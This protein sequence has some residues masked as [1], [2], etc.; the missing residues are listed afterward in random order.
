MRVLAAPSFVLLLFAFDGATGMAQEPTVSVQFAPDARIDLDG[1]LT[2]RAWQ[3]AGRIPELFQQ[4]PN[5][6]QPTAFKTQVRILTDGESLYI[7]VLA[8]DPRPERIAVHSMRRDSEMEGDDTFSVVLDTF[9]DRRSAFLFRINPAGARQDG[10]IDSSGELSLDW[11]GIWDAAVHRTA[12]G[13]TAEIEIPSKTLRFSRD[14]E[15]W[16]FNAERFV[17]RD[18]LTLRWA[19]TTLDARLT[20]LRRAG[21]LTGAQVMKQGL[22]LSITPF[23]LADGDTGVGEAAAELEG[24][25]GLDVTYSFT[26]QLS[27]VGTINTDFAETEVDARQVN[28]TRFPLFFPEKRTFFLE[29]SNQF[30]FAAGLEENFIPFFSRR[31]GLVAGREVP[32]IGGLKLVGRQGNLGIGLL[33]VQTQDLEDVGGMELAPGSNL[34]AG[35]FTYDANDELRLGAILTNGN[36]GSAE[37]N[38][39]V[40]A[41]LNWATS[42]FL[43]DRNLRLSGWTTRSYGDLREGQRSGWGIAAFYPNDLWDLQAHVFQFGA[44][45][46]P[47]LG[48]LPRPGT[49]RYRVEANWQP[50]PTAAWLEWMRQYFVEF[51]Y[52]RVDDLEGNEESWLIWTA[53]IKFLTED[54]EDIELNF[55]P[56]GESL[57][58][59]FEID[60]GVVIPPGTYNFNRY[61]VTVRSSTSRPWRLGARV[62]FGGFFGGH[63]TT[64][65]TLAS[66]TTLSHHLRLSFEM[67][68][69]W[70]DLPQGTVS[71]NIW[72]FRA[73]YD[74]NPD[75]SFSSFTQFDTESHV[76]G[77]NNRFRWIIEPGKELFV[78]WNRGWEKR[79]GGGFF[80]LDQAF[81]RVTVKLSWTLRP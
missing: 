42:S 33:D 39:L 80:R 26:P 5:P 8:V 51:R 57:D 17:A 59:P 74:A 67:E 69:N 34:F 36:P 13:W 78:V 3:D 41:D 6:G 49:R 48:F 53:P 79:E 66:L 25:A 24:D 23:A 14:R 50:R 18:L 72:K 73:T 47:A 22:G 45:L 55:L 35:R 30:D 77:M 70:G 76:V 58:A 40:G 4:E 27:A 64:L 81:E 19:G 37:E 15:T 29:G 9:G 65:E 56:Q 32:I 46:D 54:G 31:V 38:T 63:L 7:G 52:I 20:D 1:R 60:E 61:R 43:G 62:W 75:L 12:D 71:K 11:D 2:E 28:L 21:R 10:L 16:G 44:A 68:N